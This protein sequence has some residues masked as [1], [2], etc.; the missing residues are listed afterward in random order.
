MNIQDATSNL[1]PSIPTAYKLCQIFIEVGIPAGVVNVVFG[2]GSKVGQAL[3]SHPDI[4]CVSFTGGTLTGLR[5]SEAAAGKKISLEVSF[6]YHIVLTIHT[7]I[8][9]CSL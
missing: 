4:G 8:L 7:H 5:I 9:Y 2:T 6:I 1:L 3:V